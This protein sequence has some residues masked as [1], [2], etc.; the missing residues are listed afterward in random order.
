MTTDVGFLATGL[1]PLKEAFG[2]EMGTGN[3]F[4]LPCVASSINTATSTGIGSKAKRETVR[5]RVPAVG[6]PTEKTG[7]PPPQGP[8]P[9]AVAGSDRKGEAGRRTLSPS[10]RPISSTKLRGKRI[11]LKENA[12][13]TPSGS[14]AV[15][16]KSQGIEGESQ[17]LSSTCIEEGGGDGGLGAEERMA[18]GGYAGAAE[19]GVG[20]GGIAV[21]EGGVVGERSSSGTNSLREVLLKLG[22]FGAEQRERLERAQRFLEAEIARFV[23]VREAPAA[24]FFNNFVVCKK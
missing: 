16:I 7:S 20:D 6:S 2:I 11:V 1:T 21:G 22:E 10:A 5:V 9:G 14:N 15:G 19:G 8:P 18:G 13:N 3:P 24:R 23:D 4:A 12:K 17:P